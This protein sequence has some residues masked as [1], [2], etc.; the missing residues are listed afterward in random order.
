MPFHC[1]AEHPELT[2]AS[3]LYAINLSGPSLADP[4][5]LELIVEWLDEYQLSGKKHLL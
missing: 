3:N 2:E 5:T 4:A 1:W